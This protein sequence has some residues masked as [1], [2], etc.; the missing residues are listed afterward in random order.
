MSFKARVKDLGSEAATDLLCAL[1]LEPKRSFA[2]GLLG[3]LGAC[4][5]GTVAGLFFAP[6]PGREL[7]AD[8]LKTLRTGKK[9]LSWRK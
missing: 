2:G 9:N 1:G 6:R 3:F 4:A 8:V 5:V 7:F